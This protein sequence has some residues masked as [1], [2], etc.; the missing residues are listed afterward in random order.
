MDEAVAERGWMIGMF[1][2]QY[3]FVAVAAIGAFA[4]HYQDE[5]DGNVGN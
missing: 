1:L 5:L 4:T 3:T 2:L